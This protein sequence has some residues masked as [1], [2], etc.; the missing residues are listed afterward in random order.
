MDNLQ[1]C[2]IIGK[3]T[4]SQFTEEKGRLDKA[5]WF[6][7]LVFMYTVAC[8]SPAFLCLFLPTEV[9]ENGVRL[10][11]LEGASPVSFR[12]LV[13]NYFHSGSVTLAGNYFSSGFDTCW[14]KARIL[15]LRLVLLPLTFLVPSLFWATCY[16][17]GKG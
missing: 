4:D 17:D 13:E 2:L 5:F 6:F 7:A 9:T 16:T 11:V 12:S 3:S 1:P 14:Y 15:S 8:Y 10:I